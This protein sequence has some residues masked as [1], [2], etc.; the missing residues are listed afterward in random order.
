M[1]G[2]MEMEKAKPSI[3]R[4]R[5]PWCLDGAAGGS[6]GGAGP[7]VAGGD[8][9]LALGVGHRGSI[10]I[11]TACCGVVWLRRTAVRVSTDGQVFPGAGDIATWNSGCVGAPGGG[12]APRA[13]RPV[14]AA[15]EG[16]D[17]DV[18]GRPPGARCLPVRV[19]DEHPLAG[20]MLLAHHDVELGRPGPVLLAGAAVLQPWVLDGFATEGGVRPRDRHPRLRR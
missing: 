15:D 10:R 9:P 12:P 6:F 18:A 14:G 3:G 17:D 4:T 8:W 2:P 5:N 13:R 16:R 19:V 11:Q 20:A 1:N 7:I